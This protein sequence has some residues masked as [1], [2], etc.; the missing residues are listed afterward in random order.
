MPSQAVP[1]TELR[2]LLCSSLS[3]DSPNNANQNQQTYSKIEPTLTE[4]NYQDLLGLPESLQGSTQPPRAKKVVENVKSPG[5]LSG[6]LSS[7][8]LSFYRLVK[9]FVACPLG[10]LVSHAYAADNLYHKRP[11]QEAKRNNENAVVLC[12]MTR[13]TKSRSHLLGP[14]SLQQGHNRWILSLGALS[15]QDGEALRIK[16][17]E[18]EFAQPLGLGPKLTFHLVKNISI[19]PTK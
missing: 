3:K 6:I 5:F 1:E 11:Q 13:I 15:V 14:S 18:A 8:L 19:T 7:V 2:K 9:F 12:I 17:V 16:P 10:A 4:V